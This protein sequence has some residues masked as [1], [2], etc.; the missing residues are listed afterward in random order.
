MTQCAQPLFCSL[1]ALARGATF[2]GG[3][4]AVANGQPQSLSIPTGLSKAESATEIESASL[5]LAVVDI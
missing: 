5:T 3:I 1:S 4:R 2:R